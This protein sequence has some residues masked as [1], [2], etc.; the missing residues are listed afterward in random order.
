MYL[1]EKVQLVF[2]FSPQL[3]FVM[4]NC[5]LLM[6]HLIGFTLKKIAVFLTFSLKMSSVN[7]ILYK[8]T[9]C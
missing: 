6:L 3:F 4:K 9:Y 1:R 5:E 8:H 7:A 2:K